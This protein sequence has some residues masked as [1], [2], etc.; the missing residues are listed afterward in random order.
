M[1]NSILAD[2]DIDC[3]A[4]FVPFRMFTVWLIAHFNAIFRAAWA[5]RI[6]RSNA[7]PVHEL[8]IADQVD[9]ITV[10][11]ACKKQPVLHCV[12][13][14]TTP[15]V[16]S[17]AAAFAMTCPELACIVSLFGQFM[18]TPTRTAVLKPVGVVARC[19]CC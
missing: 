7:Q 14:M 1:G 6:F 4:D 18:A 11:G 16:I 17:A 5:G 3:Y 10:T 8:V 13:L 9:C 19:R 12:S 15:F 2:A